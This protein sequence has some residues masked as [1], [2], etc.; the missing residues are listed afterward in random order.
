MGTVERGTR[1]GSVD[2]L[3]ARTSSAPADILLNV[4]Y[5]E[6]SS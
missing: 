6:L 3:A 4:L 2:T 5:V 1:C